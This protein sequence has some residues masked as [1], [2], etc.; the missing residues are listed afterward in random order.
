MNAK[1]ELAIDII[2]NLPQ[3]TR[4]RMNLGDLQVIVGAVAIKERIESFY[5]L[6]YAQQAELGQ[7]KHSK[8]YCA[9]Q[10]SCMVFLGDNPKHK[11]CD[12]CR[13]YLREQKR[14]SEAGLT[15]KPKVSDYGAIRR[16]ERAASKE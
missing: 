5:R 6:T 7:Y 2:K 13:A 4:K 9:G 1:R 14:R 11:T 8:G 10:P 12:A 15:R 3:A 16:R